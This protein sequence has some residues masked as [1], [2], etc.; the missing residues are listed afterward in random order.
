[1]KRPHLFTLEPE[2]AAAMIMSAPE[3]L[4]FTLSDVAKA[5]RC[6]GAEV[7]KA[8]QAGRL[9]ASGEPDG[10]G[11]YLNVRVRGDHLIRWLEEQGQCTTT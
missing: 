2:V 9:I 6:S 8:L 1:M 10:G 5:G 3:R 11:G 4:L 7:L